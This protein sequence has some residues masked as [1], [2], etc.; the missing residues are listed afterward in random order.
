MEIYQISLIIAVGFAIIEVLTFT[1][2]FLSFSIGMIAVALCQ[3][4]LNGLSWSRD[5]VTFSVITVIVV[6]FCRLIFKNRTDQIQ[7]ADEDVN[8]Y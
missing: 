6:V 8:R 1:F 3:Y 2:L 4:F 7:S 5:I